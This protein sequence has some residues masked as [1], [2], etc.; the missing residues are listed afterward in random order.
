MSITNTLYA[1]K[2]KSKIFLGQ[3]YF[4]RDFVG[5]IIIANVLFANL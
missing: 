3:Y 4:L 2:T 5:K 1:I